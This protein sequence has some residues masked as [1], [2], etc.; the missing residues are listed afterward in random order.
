MLERDIYRDL[1]RSIGQL[2]N[3]QGRFAFVQYHSPLLPY[4]VRSRPDLTVEVESVQ[5]TE[6]KMTCKALG[7]PGSSQG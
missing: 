4:P 6:L 7:Q 3:P 2:T 5:V 1:G